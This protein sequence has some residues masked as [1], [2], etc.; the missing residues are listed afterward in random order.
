MWWSEDLKC[1][2]SGG[3]RMANGHLTRVNDGHLT[4]SDQ[5]SPELLP[6]FQSHDKLF[7]FGASPV[8]KSAFRSDN[9]E[10]ALLQNPT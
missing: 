2:Q 8:C 10:A 6:R 7:D 3:D 1:P 4:R 5:R 9:Y